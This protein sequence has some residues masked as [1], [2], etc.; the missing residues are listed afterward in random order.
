MELKGNPVH[1]SKNYPF[2]HIFQNSI[3]TFYFTAGTEERQQLL[4]D[5]WYFKC[6]CQRCEDPSDNETWSDSIRCL[7]CA[8][9]NVKKVNKQLTNNDITKWV[10]S[11]CQDELNENQVKQIICLCKNQWA[12]KLQE[13]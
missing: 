12:E 3:C 9:S 13:W 10:C 4:Y 2:S 6:C 11:N 7:Q 5:Q 8:K 1:M